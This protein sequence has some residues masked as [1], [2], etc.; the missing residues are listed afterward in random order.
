MITA[1]DQEKQAFLKGNESREQ[2]LADIRA[3]FIDQ[4]KGKKETT[5]CKMVTKQ[6]IL[7]IEK[8]KL[9]PNLSP[10]T[11]NISCELKT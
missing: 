6:P 2:A 3:V 11:K 7:Y 10:Y 5:I 1:N 4:W 8:M 9:D